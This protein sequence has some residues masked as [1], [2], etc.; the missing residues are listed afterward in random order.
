MPP[1]QKTWIAL[2]HLQQLGYSVTRTEWRGQVE[3]TAWP[4]SPG[5]AVLTAVEQVYDE[6]RAVLELCR[7]VEQRE[8]GRGDD[9]PATRAA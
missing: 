3:Y 6:H 4:R 8:H 2:A 5:S 9:G 1:S 7:R